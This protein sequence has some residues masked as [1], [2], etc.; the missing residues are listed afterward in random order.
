MEFFM[1]V[2]RLGGKGLGVCIYRNIYLYMFCIGA[3]N[4][5]FCQNHGLVWVREGLGWVGYAQGWMS[6]W[7][8]GFFGKCESQE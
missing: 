2:R 8:L 3:T 7:V 1:K 4:L 6:H 5:C